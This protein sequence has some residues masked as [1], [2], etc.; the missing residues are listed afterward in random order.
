MASGNGVLLQREAER[1]DT[2]IDI[3]DRSGRV[4]STLPL[5]S[6]SYDTPR[7]SPDGTRLVMTRL[8][9]GETTA[10]LWMVDL[11]R[12]TSARFT[13]D[14]IFDNAPAWTP[15]GRRVIYG[16]DR[17]G[18]RELYWKSADGAGAEELLADVPNLF[19]DPGDLSLD[20]HA[21]VYRSLSG[22]TGEDIWMLPL[23]GQRK[24]SPLI[25]TRFNE[26]DPALSPDGK[27]IAYRSD[28]S[29]RFEI[30][31]RSFP[32]LG[33]QLRVSTAGASPTTNNSLTRVRWRRDGRELFFIGGDGQ[34]LMS[35]A[36]EPGDDIRFGIPRPLLKLPQGTFGVEVSGDGQRVFACV[37]AGARGRTV[38]NLLMN[39]EREL[40]AAK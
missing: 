20:G 35:V 9:R 30:H 19:N 26:L 22:K 24:P 23:D 37:P 33:R 15:D 1:I 25:V 5:P 29:G 36:V 28:E 7:V 27:W 3:F 16:S 10:P 6:A 39:W 8:K 32:A 4:T 40:R 13:I 31:A 14:G 12:G 2:K 38:L 21:L 11:A 34:T 18:G 17:T